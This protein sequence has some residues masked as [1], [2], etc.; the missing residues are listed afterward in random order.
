M[1]KQNILQSA[2]H[3][4]M[5]SNTMKSNTSVI[6]THFQA[7]SQANTDAAKKELKTQPQLPTLDNILRDFGE[8]SAVFLNA[9]LV[10]QAHLPTTDSKSELQTAYQ[11]WQ[12]FLHLAYG[13]FD[14]SR[15]EMF[16][17]HTYLSILA[18][19]LAYTVISANQAYLQ[20]KQ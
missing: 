20:E 12:K 18:K 6:K 3:K 11:Q 5:K 16:F 15:Q 14:G 17:V 2:Q 1:Q 8:S 19:I 13:Q 4:S 10:M 9:M 7:I